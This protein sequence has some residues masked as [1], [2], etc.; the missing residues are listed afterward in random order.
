[1][2]SETSIVL[3]TAVYRIPSNDME[4]FTAVVFCKIEYP[5]K[6]LSYMLLPDL[7]SILKREA[8]DLSETLVT[9]HTNLQDITAVKTTI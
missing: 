2:I 3:Q 4:V 6:I 8:T 7:A 5:A 1:M 9:S